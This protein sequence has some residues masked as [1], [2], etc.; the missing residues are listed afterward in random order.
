MRRM[1]KLTKLSVQWFY[2]LL[3]RGECDIMDFKEQLD[4]K[5]VFGKSIRS[6]SGS[7]EELAR[8]VV[9][10]ANYKG[11]FLF[12]G[13]QDST[14]EI[15]RQFVYEK[16]KIFDLVKQVQDRT[17]PSIT[18]IPHPITIDGVRLLVLEIPFSTQMHRTSK[19]EYLIRSNDGNRSIEPYEMATIMSEKNLIVFDQKVWNIR[20]LSREQDNLGNPLPGWQSRDRIEKLLKMIG[21]VRPDSPYL[22]K[23]VQDA[24]SS[25]GL[26][27]E[28]EGRILPTTA[29]LL[30]IG[31]DLALKELPFASIS[32][33]R[34]FEDGTY[35][36]YEYSGNIIESVDACY[37]QLKAEIQQR[38]FHFGLFREYV[39][40]Y[41]EVVLRELL[42]NAV[43]H[44]DYSRQQIIQISKY[45][46]HIEIE[47]PGPFP[48]GIDKTNFLRQSNARNPNIMDVFRE[49][50]YTEKAGS[51]FN[52][53][54]TELLSKGKKTPVPVETQYSLTFVVE[55][56]IISEKLL[57]LAAE[58]RQLKGKD[59]DM[60]DLLVLNTIISNGKISFG[61]LE[62][63]PNISR[64]TLRHAIDE[65][66]DL[67]FIE[68]T[69]KTSGMLYI[70]NK[71]KMNT[72]QERSQYLKSRKQNKIKQKKDILEYVEEFGQITNSEA[73]T[74]LGLP[75]SSREYVSRILHDLV[76]DGS[77]VP[78]T[79]PE[80]KHRVYG[81]TQTKKQT[82]TR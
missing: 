36:H 32:Y 19:G 24:L 63:T 11:G 16:Q 8:D 9:A 38:E 55:A 6:F 82:K 47:S 14:K 15:N 30:F 2:D 79:S 37:T 81:K 61:Q 10:F 12:V 43:A 45:P 73:R 59:I 49:I 51:G 22:R 46:T 54:F 3:E 42:M 34:Y 18:L 78:L 23:P 74:H 29:G 39:E 21:S 4:D 70:L 58:Y 31:S 28:E 76:K 60:D 40:D 53:V 25:L 48:E 1:K 5:R 17:F 52:K 26:Q 72:P 75:D 13:I 56:E 57:E 20:F 41:P 69:G 71:S 66:T 7:Y 50:G 64:Y 62:V 77:M 35:R 68:T 67:G 65:L 33:N 44:R 80:N 27:K